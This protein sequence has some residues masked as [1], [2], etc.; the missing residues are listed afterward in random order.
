MKH[1]TNCRDKRVGTYRDMWN[2]FPIAPQRT[3]VSFGHLPFNHS[4]SNILSTA[5]SV[6]LL[7]ASILPVTIKLTRGNPYD[8]K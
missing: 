8:K 6:F 4:A 3:S 1:T 5:D 7:T 2:R